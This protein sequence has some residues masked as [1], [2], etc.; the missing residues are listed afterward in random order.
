MVNY[1]GVGLTVTQSCRDNTCKDNA[2]RDNTAKWDHE[3]RGGRSLL[4]TICMSLPCRLQVQMQFEKEWRWIIYHSKPHSLGVRS[5][6]KR[7]ERQGPLTTKLNFLITLTR[8]SITWT[9]LL[10][11]CKIKIKIATEWLAKNMIVKI[12]MHRETGFSTSWS[13]PS[14]F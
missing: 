10:A 9:W 5:K 3:G 11:T 13:C 8:P 4:P 6:R 2:C 12:L 14:V 7:K 1:W